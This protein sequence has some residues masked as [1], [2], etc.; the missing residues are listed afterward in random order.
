MEQ[1]LKRPWLDE[2]ED[3]SEYKRIRQ[4]YRSKQR[5]QEILYAT[6]ATTP[7]LSALRDGTTEIQVCEHVHA[8]RPV[9]EQ[10]T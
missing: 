7:V 3:Y 4:E 2:I 9:R 10:L 5:K 1:V 8:L 6:A